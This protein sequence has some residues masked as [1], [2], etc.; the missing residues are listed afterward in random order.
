MTRF[1]LLALLAGVSA[2]AAGLSTSPAQ[3]AGD[4]GA[5][6]GQIKLSAAPEPRKVDVTNDKAHCLSKG[7]QVYED[8]VVN[9]KNKGVKNVVVWLRPD[10]ENRRDPFPKDKVHPNLAKAPAKNHV[11]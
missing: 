8:L 1:R 11:I 4:W 3:N 5:V 2:L 9:P 6:K 10:T 7:P